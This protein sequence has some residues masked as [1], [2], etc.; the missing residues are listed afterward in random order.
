MFSNFFSPLVFDMQVD[1]DA[2]TGKC[3]SRP[4]QY[5]CAH[6]YEY[7]KCEEEL[8]H[9][10]ILSCFILVLISICHF[11]VYSMLTAVLLWA[12][13]TTW[14]YEQLTACFCHVC[15]E[16]LF[17]LVT[18][19]TLSKVIYWIYNPSF[20]FLNVNHFMIEEKLLK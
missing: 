14:R 20:V 12:S 8:L 7:S 19:W 16:L 17:V 6:I 9:E 13:S 5:P 2:I 15:N 4:K 10:L 1:E 11:S 18:L 3:F